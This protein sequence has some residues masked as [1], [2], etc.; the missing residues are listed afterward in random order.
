[1]GNPLSLQDEVVFSRRRATQLAKERAEW[2]AYL[3]G[4]RVE[5]LLGPPG[6]YLVTT[7]SHDA[8]RMILVEDC[9]DED[10]LDMATTRR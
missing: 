4:C 2:L 7:G 9:E 8:G 6:R 1:V 3:G 10:C 5:T